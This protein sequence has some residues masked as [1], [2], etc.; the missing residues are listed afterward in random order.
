MSITNDSSL[1]ATSGGFGGGPKKVMKKA[2]KACITRTHSQQ[3]AN[4]TTGFTPVSNDLFASCAADH[5]LLMKE[6][7]DQFFD[8]AVNKMTKE[9]IDPLVKHFQ[10]NKINEYGIFKLAGFF[11]K[12]LKELMKIK[13]EA[14]AGIEALQTAFVHQYTHCFYDGGYDHDY[15]KAIVE[16]RCLKLEVKE[17][18]KAEMGS[19]GD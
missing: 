9:D 8:I 16:K 19:M 1:E 15:L 10:D 13:G 3:K 17:E 2:D 14:E 7:D 18:V 5:K 12:S 11:V 6:D 4:A